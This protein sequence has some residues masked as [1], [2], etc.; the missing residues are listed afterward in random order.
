VPPGPQTQ[1]PAAVY[2]RPQGATDPLVSR[3]GLVP[4]KPFA[5]TRP[6][7]LL[8][9]GLPPSGLQ[10]GTGRLI[11]GNHDAQAGGNAIAILFRGG[12]KLSAVQSA[13]TNTPARASA[14]LFDAVLAEATRFSG[15]THHR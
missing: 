10:D 3:P 1:V 9:D 6:V 14:R 4:K 7:Q 8:I 5:L 13:R 11:D 15:K 2:P 12:V